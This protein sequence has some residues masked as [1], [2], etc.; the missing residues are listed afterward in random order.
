MRGKYKAEFRAEG[1]STDFV[2]VC[3]GRV[4]VE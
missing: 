3:G 4:D 2:I 1:G